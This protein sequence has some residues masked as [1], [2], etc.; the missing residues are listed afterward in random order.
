[1]T[2]ASENALW[3]LPSNEQVRPVARQTFRTVQI[4]NSMA[5]VANNEQ[6][7]GMHFELRQNENI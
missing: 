1:M 6:R 5:S 3:C 4:G 2:A 7:L